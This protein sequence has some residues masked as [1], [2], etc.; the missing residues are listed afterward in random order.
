[1]FV[2]TIQG[3]LR[4]PERFRAQGER[5]NA[6]LRPG[7]TG[8]LGSTSGVTAD[9]TGFVAVRFASEADARANSERAEQGAWWAEMEPAFADITFRDCADVD[10]LMGGGSDE[11]GFVQVIQGRVKDQASARQMLHDMT[12]QLAE[13][14]P[15]VLG[16]VMAWHGDDGAFTQ[17]MYF[18]SEAAA[19][20]GEASEADEETDRQYRD[21]MAAEPTF[22]DLTD[23]VYA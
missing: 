18:R 6:E 20:A 16:G 7:A 2:Q 23:P 5:W 21:I 9:G 11:A 14:R 1:M 10:E 15:D 3:R 4:D 8:F 17:I 19:R 12:P 22:L 13:D